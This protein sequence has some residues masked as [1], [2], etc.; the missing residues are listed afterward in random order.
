MDETI[1]SLKIVIE[2]EVKDG[3][4]EKIKEFSKA[5]KG[6]KTATKDLDAKSLAAFSASL[7]RISGSMERLAKTADAVQ[8]I[9]SL[10]G[11]MRSM[12]RIGNDGESFSKG[13]DTMAAALS[14][15]ESVSKTFNRQIEGIKNAGSAFYNIKAAALSLHGIEIPDD[16]RVNLDRLA[17]TVERASKVGSGLD[18]LVRGLKNLKSAVDSASQTDPARLEQVA[19]LLES[20]SASLKGIDF[21]AGTGVKNI[22]QGLKDLARIGGGDFNRLID[23]LVNARVA[24]EQF[25]KDLGKDVTQ[26]EMDRFKELSDAL[27]KVADGYT[28]LTAARNA[29]AN[30]PKGAKGETTPEAPKDGTQALMGNIA[31]SLGQLPFAG[32]FF[33]QLTSSANSMTSAFSAAS[34]ASGALGATLGPVAIGLAAVVAAV[35]GVQKYI[36]FV[37]DQFNKMVSTLSKVAGAIKDVAV[38]AFEYLKGK[39]EGIG[40]SIEGF[41]KGIAD[42][43]KNISSFGKSVSKMLDKFSGSFFKN[44]EKSFKSLVN[45]VKRMALRKAINAIFK[46]INDSFENLV[47]FSRKYGTEFADSMDMFAT[48]AKYLNNSIVAMVSPIIN[49]VMP[50]FDKLV[51]KV[52]ELMNAFNQLFTYFS[53]ANE[54]TKAIKNAKKYGEEADK[55]SKKQKKLNNA[56][57]SFDE[58]HKLNGDN[59]KGKDFSTSDFEDW[60]FEIRTLDDLFDYLNEKLKGFLSNVKDYLDGIDWRQIK[61]VAYD[62]GEGIMKLLNSIFG[63]EG[64]AVRLGKSL[65]EV[66]NTAFTFAL[67]AVEEWD[68]QAWGRSFVAFFEGLFDNLD[69]TAIRMTFEEFGTKLAEYLNTIFDAEAL[70]GKFGDA[71]AKGFNSV[72]A[73]VSNFVKDIN[74][75]QFGK[76]L[77]IAFEA[78]FSN[79]DY[80]DLFVTLA[81]LINKVFDAVAAWVSESD[82]PEI[83]TKIGDGLTE[84]LK[85][86]D[87]VSIKQGVFGFV[88]SLDEAI[89]NLFSDSE[90]MSKAGETLAQAFNT[91]KGAI[92]RFWDGL[93]AEKVGAGLGNFIDSF[94]DTRN[95]EGVLI[96]L[97]EFPQKILSIIANAFSNIETKDLGR[98]IGEGITEAIENINLE[99]IGSNLSTIGTK[100]GEFFGELFDKVNFKDLGKKAS[101]L[102]KKLIAAIADMLNEVDW[103]ELG[104]DLARGFNIM[105]EDFFGDEEN[106]GNATS[107]VDN[108][109]SF[110]SSLLEN[111]KWE[112]LWENIDT[113]LEKLPLED[114]WSQITQ[115]TIRFWETKRVA[116]KQWI[117]DEIQGA[118]KGALEL[119]SQKLQDGSV[120]ED[121]LN[122]LKFTGPAAMMGQHPLQQELLSWFGLDDGSLADTF[123]EAFPDLSELFGNLNFENL[124]RSIAQSFGSATNTIKEMAGSIKNALKPAL[125]GVKG[126]FDS[127]KSTVDKIYNKIK[128]WIKKLEDALE[129]IG[130]IEE[131]TDWFENA[132]IFGGV[133]GAIKSRKH[134]TGMQGGVILNR[135]TVFGMDGDTRLVGGEAGREAVVGVGSLS[136]MIQSSVL[137][138]M[139][140]MSMSTA[141][142]AGVRSAMQGGGTSPVVDVTLKCDSETLFRMVKQ[143]QTAYNGRYHFVEDFA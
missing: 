55:S 10:S 106:L 96:H 2:T 100:I 22:S 120:W 91:I 6:I 44:V 17:T 133:A 75:K 109:T 89:N 111:I 116:V 21:S 62:L 9:K 39:L 103:A 70:F 29:Y 47:A 130:V 97:T 45:M 121:I 110:L 125:D 78:A 52:V 92:V 107:I 1:D 35:Q 98:R 19:K 32:K 37:N 74:L 38:G 58:I 59:G 105:T 127:I 61:G 93:D 41:A 135:G 76:D 53:G 137:G 23:N 16:A 51:D 117:S 88:N 119:A 46:D 84:G 31:G 3:S 40:K 134:A 85:T 90:L 20:F 81:T 24:L 132:G 95:F 138:A 143:G 114:M 68:A 36:Q 25:M 122:V 123:R 14:R 67:G 11:F 136:T 4:T 60:V 42:A 54:W 66:I 99:Q 129:K 5:I 83:A 102:A 64:L 34:K 27:Y 33:G 8:S 79:I 128:D 139:S 126:V 7:S 118:I 82:L 18:A 28:K 71:V 73:G 113:F 63:D 50:V 57:L 87:W 86:L 101:G 15:L 49:M 140:P 80:N 48:S 142:E 77:G 69:W 94:L 104:S 131:D 72:L 56:I 13:V 124:E 26:E 108:I 141:V 65:A 112:E 30:A 43:V 115:I 12:S